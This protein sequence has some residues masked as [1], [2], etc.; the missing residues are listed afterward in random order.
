MDFFLGRITRRHLDVD[1]FAWGTDLPQLVD[2][3]VGRGWSEVGGHPPEQQRDL[4]RG[5]VELGFAP[6]ARARDGTVLVGGGPWA[7]EPWPAG[8]IEDA[9][10]GEV[11]DL[12][13]PV[14]SPAVQVEI[15]RMMPTWVP[16]LQRREKDSED[17]ARLS[18]AILWKRAT[19]GLAR[20]HERSAD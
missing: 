18:E 5:A 11:W 15:K 17:I 16:W 9:V 20:E 19:E 4:V 3:L 14:I 13:C 12:R 1:W 8:M 10:L 6:L 2:V 7:G